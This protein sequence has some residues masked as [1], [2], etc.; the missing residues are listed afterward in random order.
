M[1]TAIRFPFKM[2]LVH[3]RALLSFEKISFLLKSCSPFFGGAGGD[4]RYNVASF[5]LLN[6]Q[7]S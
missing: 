4:E 3:A 7:R 2:T 6:N 1:T 5:T